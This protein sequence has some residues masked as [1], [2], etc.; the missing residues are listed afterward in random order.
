MA[1]TC[2]VKKERVM[3]AVKNGRGG[4]GDNLFCEEGKSDED[5]GML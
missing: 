5:N 4:D 1:T 3:K 2:F